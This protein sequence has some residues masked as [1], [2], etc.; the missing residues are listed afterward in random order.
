MHE[1]Y[2]AETLNQ[3]EVVT[4]ELVLLQEQS[5]YLCPLCWYVNGV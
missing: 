2:I 5:H 4:A 3:D 1:V